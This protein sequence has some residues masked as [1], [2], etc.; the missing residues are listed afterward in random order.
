MTLRQIIQANHIPIK[1][2]DHRIMSFLGIYIRD[3]ILGPGNP[4]PFKKVAE[5]DNMVID[6]PDELVPHVVTLINEAIKKNP[7]WAIRKRTPR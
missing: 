2:K 6:Y 3:E 4:T 5:G 1:I 7:T